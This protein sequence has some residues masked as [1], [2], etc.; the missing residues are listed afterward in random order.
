MPDSLDRTI[1]RTLMA[2]G[3]ITWTELA[4]R[5]GLSA[6]SAAERV[7]KLEEAGFI[8]GYAALVNPVALGNT[9]LAFVALSVTDPAYHESVLRWVRN[10]D[11][12]QECHIIAGEHD[13]LLKVRCR[14]PEQLERFLREDV[15]SLP[16]VSGTRT[17][18][19][20]STPKE[21]TRIPLP[22]E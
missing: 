16:G 12:V 15:R 1:L 17:T 14:D 21:T 9:T 6:P 8:E 20:L 18:V 2:E 10:T 5:V 11:E 19:T 13:Y 7:R 4:A 22:E 3:R